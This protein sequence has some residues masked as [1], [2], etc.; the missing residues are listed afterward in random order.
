MKVFLFS[1]ENFN[2]NNLK[3][4]EQNI[5]MLKDYTECLKGRG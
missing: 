1:D 5:P 3:K 2:E 4:K